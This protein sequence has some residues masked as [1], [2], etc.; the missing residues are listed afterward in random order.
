MNNSIKHI[1]ST[2]LF[3]IV[4]ISASGQKILTLEECRKQ[5]IEFN[6]ELKNAALQ[7]EES[8]AYQKVARTAYLPAVEA[9]VSAM[10]L[11]T[12]ENISMPGHFLP[13]AES[14]EAAEAGIFTETSNVWSPGINLGLKNLALAYGGLSVTQP[15]YT[16]GKIKYSNLQSD[17]GVEISKL[18]YNLKYSEV[19]DKTDEA[20]WNVIMIKSNIDLAK[21]YIEM[22]TVLGD[23]MSAMYE[24]GLQPASEK[25]KV[26]V[27]KN[28]AELNLMKAQNGLKISKMYL[29]Q[30]LGQDLDMDIQLNYQPEAENKLF[31]LSNGLNLA[32]TN[33]EEL[34]ILEQQ[35]VISEYDL[36]LAKADY[37][38]QAGLSLQYTGAYINNLSE[39]VQ[40][41][42][43]IAAQVSI[44]IFHWGQNKQKQKAAKLKIQQAATN[45]QNTNELIN[46]EVMQVKIQVEEAFESILIAKRNIAEAEES[47]EET[48]ASFDV[49]LNT[50]T[51]LLNAQANWQ[52]AQA[53]LIK[54]NA[55][56]NVL[57]TKWKKATGNMSLYD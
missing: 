55:Q 18:A 19:I 36:K 44:P 1:L 35:K 49:G 48:K 23:Q 50:T 56:F 53:Q 16:G 30:I 42:P 21:K 57:K 32:S 54:A 7:K 40:F 38:P 22:L 37:L 29:N 27:Q 12:M 6:K 8:I 34:K 47:L 41:K 4:V 43:I 20:F 10:H 45:L 14:A 51:D 52:N 33:R 39:N 15:I 26:S 13:T 24:V 5:A 9:D 25:L 17:A 31:D 46:V 28:E 2:M 11:P 3:L